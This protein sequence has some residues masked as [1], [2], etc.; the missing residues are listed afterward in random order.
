VQ[1]RKK[2]YDDLLAAQREKVKNLLAK[3]TARTPKGVQTGLGQGSNKEALEL[4]NSFVNL[5]QFV[6]AGRANL[7]K[8]TVSQ[9]SVRKFYWAHWQAIEMMYEMH[10]TFVERCGSV[11]R[12]ALY[13]LRSEAEA[14]AGQKRALARDLGVEEPR[15]ALEQIAERR[16]EQAIQV[17]LALAVLE[18]QQAWARE[19]LPLLREQITVASQA[20]EAA[21]LGAQAAELVGAVGEA[22]EEAR[23]EPPELIMFDV[24]ADDLKASVAR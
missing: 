9:A 5:E 1:R 18:K 6:I 7:M 3:D 2:D 12:P 13:E 14:L 23:I 24:P 21:D 10:S 19:K 17:E 8:E 4:F 22:F 11:Y 15:A 20:Y 16:E